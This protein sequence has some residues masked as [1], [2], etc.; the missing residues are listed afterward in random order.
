M[1]MDRSAREDVVGD[2]GVLDRGNVDD[3]ARGDEPD[4][5]DCCCCCCCCCCNGDDSDDDDEALL[6]ILL[7]LLLLLL[8]VLLVEV[9]MLGSH[10][11]RANSLNGSNTLHPS[12][13]PSFSATL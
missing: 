6:F 12:M 7:L 2:G 8:F 9:T 10:P 1:D 3:R 13:S 11:C 4:V 5:L